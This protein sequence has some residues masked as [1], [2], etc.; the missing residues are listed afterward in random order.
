[1]K[2]LL[3]V[4]IA[5]NFVACTQKKAP[6]AS[7]RTK[8]AAADGKIE[9]KL[10]A[11]AEAHLK[12]VDEDLEK[13]EKEYA[14]QKLTQD[15]TTSNKEKM[16]EFR[17]NESILAKENK[18]DGYDNRLEKLKASLKN[19]VVVKDDNTNTAT[20][21]NTFKEKQ[22]PA[23]DDRDTKTADSVATITPAATAS[24]TEL[25]KSEPVSAV[26]KEDTVATAEVSEK[27]A[28]DK[29]QTDKKDHGLLPEV[30]ETAE[31]KIPEEKANLK[32]DLESG[33]VAKGE[34]PAVISINAGASLFKAQEDKT[35]SLIDS[36]KITGKL[37]DFSN[38]CAVSNSLKTENN[39]VAKAIDTAKLSEMHVEL[40]EDIKKMKTFINL[41]CSA[42]VLKVAG[43]EGLTEAKLEDSADQI[44]ATKVFV[45]DQQ[46]IASLNTL[47]AQ[48]LVLANASLAAG[49]RRSTKQ[50][51]I[52]AEKLKLMGVNRIGIREEPMSAWGKSHKS[53]V[54]IDILGNS[55]DIAEKAELEIS[56]VGSKA[57]SEGN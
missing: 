36:I 25:P 14:S 9:S 42:E 27:A 38:S 17:K 15:E 3:I 44:A 55:H 29:E 56:T 12:K 53:D 20:A 34:L 2:N 37:G 24:I 13:L 16:T 30:I 23:S 43:T 28:D 46:K 6:V 21:R 50:L 49:L 5:F 40:L 35:I 26:K 22:T 1:M 4:L 31:C 57:Y 52:M 39:Y 7:A 18:V 19:S 32:A 51:Y 8:P 11:E 47:R 48:E 41:G 33:K 45:C 10:S 54:R